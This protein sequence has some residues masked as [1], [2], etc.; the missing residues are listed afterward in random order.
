MRLL[1]SLAFLL[2]TAGCGSGG[3]GG[4]SGGGGSPPPP[5][6][7]PPVVDSYDGALDE[8][9]GTFA[10][11]GA[12]SVEF[13]EDSGHVIFETV[14]GTVS[15]NTTG[16]TTG[17]RGTAIVNGVEEYSVWFWPEENALIIS[18]PD[19]PGNYASWTLTLLAGGG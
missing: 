10:A 6:P 11:Q 2:I 1:L 19:A 4:G 17:W 3:G 9:G 14:R 18:D 5:P 15:V 12:T 13:T 7:P 16:S 8:S